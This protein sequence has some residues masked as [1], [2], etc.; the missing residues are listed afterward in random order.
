MLFPWYEMVVYMMTFAKGG[1]MGQ[2]P[3]GTNEL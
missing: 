1:S 3:E 2:V